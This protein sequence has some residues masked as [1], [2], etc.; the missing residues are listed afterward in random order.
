[1]VGLFK[2]SARLSAGEVISELLIEYLE[3][4]SPFPDIDIIVPVPLHWRRFFGRQFNQSAFLGR[5]VSQKLKLK[6]S[7]RVLVRQR[8]TQPQ[9]ELQPSDRFLNVHGAFRVRQVVKGVNFLLIDDV[10]TTG[11]TVNECARVLKRAGAE[12]IYVLTFA[13]R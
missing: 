1:L 13:R 8:N 10:Y 7:E 12:K 2:Y 5:R 9:V 3:K 6:Y 4:F 11:A